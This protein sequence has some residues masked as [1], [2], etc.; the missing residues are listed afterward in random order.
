MVKLI[1]LYYSVPQSNHSA[2]LQAGWLHSQATLTMLSV[3]RDISSLIIPQVGW[4]V[5]ARWDFFSKSTNN[6]CNKILCDKAC[7]LTFPRWMPSLLH[8]S[9]AT[10]YAGHSVSWCCCKENYHKVI[11][12]RIMQL[13]EKG[14]Q[15]SF[16]SP[17]K[18]L[19]KQKKSDIDKW[20]R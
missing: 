10:G 7:F 16:D 19:R 5:Q 20:Y 4:F 1:Q 17:R 11:K 14:K 13:R 12:I 15:T 3:Y 18:Y 8:L 6:S 9:H 2:E